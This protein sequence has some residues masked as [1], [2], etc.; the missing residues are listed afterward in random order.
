[1]IKFEKRGKVSNIGGEG[2]GL[3]K[4]GVVR[5][6]LSTI[7]FQK[8]QVS[9]TQLKKHFCNL[10]NQRQIKSTKIIG[11]Q[12]EIII[13]GFEILKLLSA[14][15]GILYGQQH[16]E[17]H[18]HPPTE[19]IAI[20]PHNDPQQCPLNTNIHLQTYKHTHRHINEHEHKHTERYINSLY[21]C[22]QNLA[23][24]LHFQDSLL[25]T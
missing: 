18:P 4:I 1:M 13:E 24:K 21:L 10:L 19:P 9:K 22:N 5:D 16:T 11:D 2:G 12:I 17:T 14:F 6:P 25:L 7:L 3:H 15:P 20:P 23:R 8:T